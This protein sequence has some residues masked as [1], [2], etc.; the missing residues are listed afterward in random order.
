MG[1]GIPQYLCLEMHQSLALGDPVAEP[2]RSRPLRVPGDLAHLIQHFVSQVGY[3]QEPLAG[4]DEDDGRLAAPAV[5][6]PVG[7]PSLGQQEAPFGQVQDNLA[8][9]LL[10]VF[11][12]YF[13]PASSV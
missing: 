13:S 1:R 3:P 11:P 12:S 8:V 7:E 4:G 5:A 6:V 10:N 2:G 9:G